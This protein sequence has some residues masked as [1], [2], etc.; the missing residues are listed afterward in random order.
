LFEAG[1]TLGD[2]TEQ[3]LKNAQFSLEEFLSYPEARF[4][5]FAAGFKLHDVLGIKKGKQSI[6]FGYPPGVLFAAGF[7]VRELYHEAKFSVEV[8]ASSQ[9]ENG[10]G[11]GKSPIPL[12]S[13]LANHDSLHLLRPHIKSSLFQ[14]FSKKTRVLFQPLLELSI[15]LATLAANFH[16]SNFRE[17]NVN[18]SD[19]DFSLYELFIGGYSLQ[20]LFCSKRFQKDSIDFFSGSYFS[21]QVLRDLRQER[22][23]SAKE[24]RDLGFKPYLSLFTLPELKESG[25]DA[26][27]LFSALVETGTAPLEL[28]SY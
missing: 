1:F 28:F 17:N 11:M 13:I 6:V 10:C 21:L 16:P 25:Y 19:L 22:N 26:Q 2:A 24:F 15:P 7:T 8:I 20:D 9:I 5:L 3:Q 14:S 27:D 23:C 4:N 18:C 12:Y